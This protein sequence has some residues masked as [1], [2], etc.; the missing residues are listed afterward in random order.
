[1]MTRAEVAELFRRFPI[2]STWPRSR[3]K[4]P[5]VFHFHRPGG[6]PRTVNLDEDD[7]KARYLRVPLAEVYPHVEPTGEEN[8]LDRYFRL[9]S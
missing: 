4:N 9:A 2:A 8:S 6:E 3:S 5:R 1:M 7:G